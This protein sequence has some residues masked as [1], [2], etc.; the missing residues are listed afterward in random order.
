MAWVVLKGVDVR[1]SWASLSLEKGMSRR[2]V[3]LRVREG[4]EEGFSALCNCKVQCFEFFFF[5][6]SDW[7]VFGFGGT[8]LAH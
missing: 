7:G 8:T 3:A 4:V 6:G 5:V 1:S 2:F